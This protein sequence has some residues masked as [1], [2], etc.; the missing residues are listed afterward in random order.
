MAH[1]DYFSPATIELQKELSSGYHETLCMCLATT[2]DTAERM[3]M[4]ATHCDVLID[5]SFNQAQWDSLCDDMVRILKEHKRE[6][7]SPLIVYPV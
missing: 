5:D 2:N 4:I 6:R 1:Y 7:P 3:S